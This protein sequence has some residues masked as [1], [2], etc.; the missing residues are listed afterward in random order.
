MSGFGDDF[1]VGNREDPLSVPYTPLVPIF[2]DPPR[3]DYQFACAQVPQT[4]RKVIYILFSSP[5]IK[6]IKFNDGLTFHQRQL[7]IGLSD[8]VELGP[9]LSL[10]SLL[11]RRSHRTV[12]W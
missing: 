11:R 12:V 1:N 9:R 4:C 2:V 6:L 3:Q 5:Q 8:K 7:E 10:V